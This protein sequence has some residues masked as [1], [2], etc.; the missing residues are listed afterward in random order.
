MNFQKMAFES[1]QQLSHMCFRL[2]RSQLQRLIRLLNHVTVILLLRD[3]TLRLK[4]HRMENRCQRRTVQSPIWMN[5]P[6]PP[7]VQIIAFYALDTP[8]TDARSWT[9]MGDPTA[10]RSMP[11]ST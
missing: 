6:S 10:Q 4:R 11:R 7:S 2:E 8:E 3:L 5:S 1:S 9:S